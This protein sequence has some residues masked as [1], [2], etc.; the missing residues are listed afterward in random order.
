MNAKAG[1]STAKTEQQARA[2]RR[3]LL[4]S[5]GRRKPPNCM[6]EFLNSLQ[7]NR[8]TTVHAESVINVVQ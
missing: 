2:I 1:R 7:H 4:E 6:Q 3:Y 8:L 5:T